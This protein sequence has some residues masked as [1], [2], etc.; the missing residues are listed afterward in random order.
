MKSR[1]IFDLILLAAIWGA[2]F[3]FMRV[4]VPEFGA[5]PMMMLRVAIAA[6]VLMP[7]VIWKKRLTLLW[8]NIVPISIV[9]IVNSAIPF[10]LIAYS[11]LYVTAGF[12]SVLNAAT[13]IFS[14]VIAFVWLKQRLSK[15]AIVGLLI[16]ICGVVFLV[17]DKIGFANSSESETAIAILSGVVSTLAYGLG[18]NYSKKKLAGVDP[19]TITTGSQFVATIVLL[20]LAIYWWPDHPPSSQGWLNVIYLAV[21]CTAL[22]QI[23]YFRLIVKIGPTNTTS[24]TFLIPIFGLLWGYIFLNEIIEINTLIA[25]SVIL[26]GTGLSTGVIRL[27]RQNQQ[28]SVGK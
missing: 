6:L 2:S 22:A 7:I 28:N 5:V 8:E 17:W 18:A 11:T 15:S 24:V 3:L 1:E 27:G 25:G 9:G 26:L 23:I 16:G 14:A 21:I 4:S 19:V 13:P 20:P 10:S 12:A